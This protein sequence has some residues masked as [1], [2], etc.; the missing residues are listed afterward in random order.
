MQG[1]SA[2]NA[3][4]K[5]RNLLY[6][7]D[8]AMTVGFAPGLEQFLHSATHDSLSRL[9]QRSQSLPDDAQ[10]QPVIFLMVS[11]PV[12]SLVMSISSEAKRPVPADRST[13]LAT[14]LFD[15][16]RDKNK[17]DLQPAFLKRV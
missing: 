1:G 17:K 8:E 5:E 6:K 4:H 3:E 11:S 12:L 16:I 14:E 10:R 7:Y 2:L 13:L 15:E 9:H